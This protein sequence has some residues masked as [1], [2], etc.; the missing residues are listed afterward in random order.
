[1]KAGKRGGKPYVETREALAIRVEGVVV[2]LNELLCRRAA[3][4]ASLLSPKHRRHRI[5]PAFH[6]LKE[7]GLG[8]ILTRNVLEGCGSLGC[9]QG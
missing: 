6:S 4:S 3:S 1:M 5:S 2:E 8:N 7:L 9:Q